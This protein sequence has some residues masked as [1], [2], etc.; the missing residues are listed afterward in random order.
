MLL[1]GNNLAIV[2]GTLALDQLLPPDPSLSYKLLMFCMQLILFFLLAEVLPKAIGRRKNIRMLEKTYALIWIFYYLLLPLSYVFLKLSRAIGKNKNNASDDS[3][4]EVFRF[5]AEQT[6][7]NQQALA[8]SLAKY[9]STTIDEI[10]TP[11]IEFLSIADSATLGECADVMHRGSYS[12]YPVYETMPANI[13][14]YLDSRDI[15]AKPRSTRVRQVLRPA[16]FFPYSLKVDTL[17]AQMR[18]LNEVMVFVVNEYGLVLGMV[19]E[20]NLAEELVGDIFAHDQKL[21]AGYLIQVDSR[22]YEIDCAMDIDD[23]MEKFSLALDKEYFETLSGYIITSCG[24]IPTKGEEI[25]LPEG[26]FTVIEATPRA[27]RRVAFK[28]KRVRM[29]AKTHQFN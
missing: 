24:R 19:T 1:T 8:D 20:E 28:P 5:I 25:S 13:I 16:H 18:R 2:T 11:L 29:S 17:H 27:V 23:F 6:P 10:M 12:R 3:R 21:E 4:L 26:V 9:S 7:D 14:G 15:L 22:L